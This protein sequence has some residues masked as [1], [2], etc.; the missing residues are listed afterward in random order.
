MTT[1]HANGVDLGIES[2]GDDDTAIPDTAAGEVAE[3]MLT[4]G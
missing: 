4:L 1:R 2:F 3:A